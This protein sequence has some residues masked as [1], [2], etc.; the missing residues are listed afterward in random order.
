MEP[1]GSLPHSQMHTTCPY[2]KPLLSSYQRISPYSRHICP[3][4]IKA[5]FYGEDL[6]APRPNLKLEDHSLSA[7]HYGLFNT[8]AA[9][10][11]IEGSFYFWKLR[12]CHFVMTLVLDRRLIEE[13]FYNPC[14]IVR[15]TA[16][17]TGI[18]IRIWSSYSFN[19]IF[20]LDTGN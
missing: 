9:T 16:F 11:H 6:L 2:P 1:E 7:A 10:F 15:N 5:S 19:L 20:G 12:I 14:F 13:N 8:F 3:F 18:S 17:Q 4:R